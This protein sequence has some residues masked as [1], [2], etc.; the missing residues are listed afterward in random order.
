MATDI[1]PE[2]QYL[3]RL[4]ELEKELSQLNKR[5]TALGWLRFISLLL[6]V[7]GT[8]LL[9]SFDV[10]IFF[11]LIFFLLLAGIFLYS[12]VLDL[13]NKEAIANQ[14]LL[15]SINEQEIQVLHHQYTHLPDGMQFKPEDHSYANDLDIFGRASLY[16][17]IN[18]TTSQQG[19]RVLASQLLHATTKETIL[20]KQEAAKE[21]SHQMKWRQQLQAYG[22]STTITIATQE[23]IE[24]WLKEKEQFSN[25]LLWQIV[26]FLLPAICIT[27][28]VFYNADIISL[29]LLNLSLLFFLFISFSI[30]KAVMPL[31]KKLNKITAEVETLS[32]SAA[33]IEQ[34]SFKST[35]LVQLQNHFLVNNIKASLAIKQLRKIFN[36]L[37]YRLNPLVFIPLNTVLLWDLQQTFALEKWKK[38]NGQ[39]VNNWFNALAQLEIL[40][41]FGNTAANHPD[42]CFPTISDEQSV[43]AAKELG[44]PLIIKS[45]RVTNDFSAEG[46]QQIELITGS[47]MAG[48]STFL[49]SVGVNMALANM[50]APVCAGSLTVSPMNI[51]SSMRISDNLEESTS[52]F[53]A[54][55]KKLKQ[56]IDAVKNNEN[57]YLLLDEILRGTNSNDRHTGSKA[58][59]KQ[60]VQHKAAGILATHDLELAKLADAY[61]QHIH[62]YHFDVQVAN[63]ELFFDYKLKTGVCQSMNASILMKKIGIDL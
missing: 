49:R 19:N 10:N 3:L 5:K 9:W 42:W 11:I 33:W 31:Y 23:K 38:H 18:R 46:R 4:T 24:E 62:N 40:C 7:A 45:K 55:L 37:D 58:L 1:L 22:L 57:V 35:L 14:K 59:I 30:S 16:Q 48:K 60:L 17:Y 20:Q 2:Q 12:V 53:Y 27:M 63:D 6:C 32:T 28:I 51:I 8:W 44:H 15:I 29:P 43:F 52:T 54:E 56:V 41:T 36:R 47:N 61:P 13:R 39:N 26:R 34:A 50:G 25:K 21:L